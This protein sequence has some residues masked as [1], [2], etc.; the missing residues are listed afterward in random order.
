MKVLKW[1]E[2]RKVYPNQFVKIRVLSSYIEGNKEVIEDMAIIKSI[3]NELVK[4]ELLKSKGDEVVYHTT[5]EK[6]M[7]EICQDVV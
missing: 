6:I 5:H 4:K 1:S 7:L 2:V 3:P